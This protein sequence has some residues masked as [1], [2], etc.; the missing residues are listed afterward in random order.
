[1]DIVIYIYT[2]CIILDY[3]YAVFPLHLQELRRCVLQQGLEDVLEE[4]PTAVAEDRVTGRE[5]GHFDSF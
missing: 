5:D 2:Y 3:R 4:E 1:M